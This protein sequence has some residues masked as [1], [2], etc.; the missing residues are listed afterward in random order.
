MSSDVA[1]ALN[2]VALT[3][4]PAKRLQIAEAARRT[5][6]EWP[7]TNFGYRSRDIR[8]IL[9]LLDE[10]ISELR[11]AN[12]IQQFDLSFMAITEPPPLLPAQGPLTLQESIVQALTVARFS[13]T[14]AERLSLLQSVVAIID[15][16]AA[17]LPVEW[18]KSTRQTAATDIAQELQIERIY[19]DLARTVVAQATAKASTA[20]VRGVEQLVRQVEK[21]DTQ[22]GKRRPQVITSLKLSLTEKLEAARRLRLARDQWELRA[23]AYRR[24]LTAARPSMQRLTESI[25]LLDDIKSLAGPD[26]EGLASLEK[27]V[28]QA[29]R[30]FAGVSAPPGLQAP[31]E[32]LARALE[33]AQSAVR[34]RAR[35]VASGEL[36]AAWDAS[37]AA[38]A[39]LM[40]LGQVKQELDRFLKL[41]ELQ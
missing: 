21:R 22:L 40:L 7:R 11:V 13:S 41:P 36:A 6:A 14:P 2:D 17:S 1:R 31:H 20:D 3:P 10:V 39:S 23:P 18:A 32:L 16:A 4:D 37:S 28:G 30:D 38:A 34:T 35:A 19:A 24:Y 26:R 27:R 8:Q 29:L 5:L 15:G 33:F 12:G 25:P 9:G